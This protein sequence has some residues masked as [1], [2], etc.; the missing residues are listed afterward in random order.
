MGLL[1]IGRPNNTS[2]LKTCRLSKARGHFGG[3]LE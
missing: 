1:G 3:V 2:G